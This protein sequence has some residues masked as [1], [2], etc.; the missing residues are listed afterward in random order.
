MAERRQ[1]RFDSL[2]QAIADAE[3][4]LANGYDKAGNWSLSQ[5]CDHLNDWITYPVSGYPKAPFP[6]G[7]VMWLLKVTMGGKI[8]RSLLTERTMPPGQPTVKTTVHSVS[9]DAAS[10]AKFREA[11]ERFMKYTGPIHPSPLFGAMDK[12]TADQLQRVHTA[13]HLSFLVPKVK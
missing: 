1:L 10:V 4:L 8:R 13:H 9:E 7:M 6:M 3:N 5:V 12:D 2:D 11:V